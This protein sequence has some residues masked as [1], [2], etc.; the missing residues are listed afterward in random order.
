MLT[1][2]TEVT[3]SSPFDL[4]L[5]CCHVCYDVFSLSTSVGNELASDEPVVRLWRSV[6]PP[7]LARDDNG[8]RNRWERPPPAKSLPDL[9]K[10]GRF[11]VAQY[12]VS[13]II[14]LIFY[15]L[16][17]SL[18]LTL[19]QPHPQMLHKKFPRLL[20]RI[21]PVVSRDKQAVIEWLVEHGKIIGIVGG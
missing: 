14:V 13:M 15:L 19:S 9:Y 17:R 6:A 10:G 20:A 11:F 2:R 5:F 21:V 4:V 18:L 12:N 1:L 16:T 3:G 8:L 7:K